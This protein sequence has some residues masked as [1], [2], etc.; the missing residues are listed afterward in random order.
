MNIDF[1]FKNEL[2]RDLK[3]KGGNIYFVGGLVRDHFLKI[4]SKDIDILV[5]N[6]PIDDL[7]SILSKY[8]SIDKVG[9]SFGIIKWKVGG[10]VI[11]VALPRTE[12]SNGESH[13]DFIINFDHTLS[14]EEDLQRRDF[15]INA[16]AY[17]IINDC[18]IDPFNGI[19][20]IDLK[21]I[22]TVSETSFYDDPLRIL[23]AVQFSG[24]FDFTLEKKTET[25]FEENLNGLSLISKERI[26]LE[27]GKLLE[28]AEGNGKWFEVLKDLDKTLFFNIDNHFNHILSTI[29]TAGNNFIDKDVK[30]A[31]LLNNVSYTDDDGDYHF[32]NYIKVFN[33]YKLANGGFNLL[34]IKQIIDAKSPY[35]LIKSKLDLK[36]FICESFKERDIF[37]SYIKMHYL[38]CNITLD[39]FKWLKINYDLC[40]SDPIYISDLNINGDDLL[41]IGFKG[42][43]IGQF[44]KECLELVHIEPCLNN[45]LILLELA[46][47][48]YQRSPDFHL[49]QKVDQNL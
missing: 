30:L 45:R 8:G 22:R 26:A 31:I 18:F 6:I 16:I 37:I 5:Q 46:N 9:K 39:K 7:E 23:R 14:V 34:K 38:L 35:A 13:T 29:R 4:A 28:K 41:S 43:Q 11:D 48:K 40:L 25:S 36:T 10:I 47:S 32:V 1:P 27:L 12:I 2:I 15:T 44:L 17:D 33:D 19:K 20:D 21:L 49:P 3:E 24:R 42:I